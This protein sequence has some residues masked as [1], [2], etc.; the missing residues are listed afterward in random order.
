MEQDLNGFF[1]KKARRIVI[2]GLENS[3][4]STILKKLNLGNIET[5]RLVNNFMV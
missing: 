4:K 2:I 1:S 5:A 3:G